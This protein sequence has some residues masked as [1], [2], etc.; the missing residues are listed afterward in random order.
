MSVEQYVQDVDQG[1]K[2]LLLCFCHYGIPSVEGGSM[3]N[4]V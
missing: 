2:D 4:D 1:V 3:L